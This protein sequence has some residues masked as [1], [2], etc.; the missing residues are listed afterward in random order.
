MGLQLTTDIVVCLIPEKRVRMET[1]VW[2]IEKDIAGRESG[3][4]QVKSARDCSSGMPAIPM[5][6]VLWGAGD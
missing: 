2:T 3:R 6:L 5:M 4:H 1:L